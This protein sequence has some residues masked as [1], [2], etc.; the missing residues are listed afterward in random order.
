MVGGGIGVVVFGT[1]VEGSASAGI[2]AHGVLI[3]SRS[4]TAMSPRYPPPRTPTTLEK[5]VYQGLLLFIA[6]PQYL[7][8]DLKGMALGGTDPNLEAGK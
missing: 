5:G 7:N 6:F 3:I 2:R 8:A 4:S 1:N